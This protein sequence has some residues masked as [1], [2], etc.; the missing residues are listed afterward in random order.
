MNGWSVNFLSV[1]KSVEK[2][3]GASYGFGDD[4]RAKPIIKL[5]NIPRAWEQRTGHE[6]SAEDVALHVF[7]MDQGVVRSKELLCFD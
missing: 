7:V 1:F 5:L 4:Q 3:P 2:N 6:F